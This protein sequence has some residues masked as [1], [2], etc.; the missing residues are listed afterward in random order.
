MD[1]RCSVKYAKWVPLDALFLGLAVY[2]VV[3]GVRD[4]DPAK[5]LFVAMIAVLAVVLRLLG[6]RPWGQYVP[7][8]VLGL[9]MAC[10]AAIF[11]SRM[12][13]ALFVPDW[14]PALIYLLGVLATGQWAGLIGAGMVKLVRAGAPTVAEPGPGDIY[15]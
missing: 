8:A 13:R 11:L 5:L 4:G 7:G 12:V 9:V 14:G 6:R 2:Y 1:R 10:G 15:P 3:T